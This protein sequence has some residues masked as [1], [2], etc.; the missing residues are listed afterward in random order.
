[1]KDKSFEK[2][3]MYLLY[4]HIHKHMHTH[5]VHIPAFTE[6]ACTVHIAFIDIS[7]LAFKKKYSTV[8]LNDEHMPRQWIR[9]QC[10]FNI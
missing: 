4:T 8:T 10:D 6:H 2:A 1:M 7:H 9:E 3:G 5:A